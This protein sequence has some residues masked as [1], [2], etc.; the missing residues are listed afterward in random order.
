MLALGHRSPLLSTLGIVAL[1]GAVAPSACRQEDGPPPIDDVADVIGVYE[2]LYAFYCECYAVAYGEELTVEECLAEYAEPVSDVEQA[3]LEAVF[4]AHPEAFEVTR[5]EAEGLRGLLGCR[6]A[7]GCPMPFTCG[8]G[9]TVPEDFV[10]DG[11]ADCEDGSDEQQDCPPG[12]TCG[13]GEAVGVSSVCDGFADCLDASDEQGCPGP[14]TCSDANEIPAQWV[15]DGVDDCPDGADEAQGCPVTCD[16]QWNDRIEGCGEIDPQVQQLL[17]D[18]FDF[19][20]I[21]G[22][23]I[24]S[25]QV[26]DGTP[27]CPEG[28]DEHFCEGGGSG[29]SGDSSGSSG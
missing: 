28:E 5:C 14:F 19:A 7:E 18:C 25:G 21:S 11:Y 2:D 15:C 8:D 4:E 24:P 13:D 26:C 22:L 29:G 3:C 1:A 6:R 23:E 16:S 12:F 10:C 9:A 27:H 17:D 20:C